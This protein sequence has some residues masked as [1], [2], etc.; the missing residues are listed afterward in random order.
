MA[1]DGKRWFEE[2]DKEPLQANGKQI[3]RNREMI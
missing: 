3:A 2:M 1:L